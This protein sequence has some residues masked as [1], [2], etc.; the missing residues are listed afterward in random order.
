MRIRCAN[1]CLLLC[2]SDLG[3]VCE[4][5]GVRCDSSTGQVIELDLHNMV[6]S[7]TVASSIAS[8]DSVSRLYDIC[9]HSARRLLIQF[10]RMPA[11]QTAVFLVLSSLFV[12]T[13]L[14]LI[15]ACL[16]TNNQM[17]KSSRWRTLFFVLRAMDMLL[18]AATSL[19]LFQRTIWHHSCSSHL[20][21]RLM[22]NGNR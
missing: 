20:Q 11:A 2:T 4:W 3:S 21:D 6:L 1:S 9:A 16:T 17:I 15:P 22:N 19:F 13:L 18:S 10:S 14:T 7:G 12:L 8:L 5:S